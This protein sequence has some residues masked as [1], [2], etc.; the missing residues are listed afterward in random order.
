MK[1]RILSANDV[2]A[3][4]PIEQAIEAMRVAFREIASGGAH[5]PLRT[6]LR[7]GAG[8]TLFMPGYLETSGGLAQKIVSVYNENP[9]RGLPAISGLVIVLDP[10]TGS[11]LAVLEGGAL[12]AIRTGAAAG[13]ATDLL[14]RPNSHVLAQFGAGG[15]AYDHVAAVVAVRPIEEVRIVSRSGQSCKR[16]AQRL[17]AEGINAFSVQD[18]AEAVREADIITCVT[19]AGQALFRDE[20][21]KS[22]AHINLMG[23]YTPDM[24]EAPAETVARA[25]VF[26]D[27]LE[28]ALAEAGDLLKPLAEGRIERSHFQ[29][30][31][32]D[33]LLGRVPGRSS[34]E[35]I[36]LFKSV[37]LA[38][39]DVAAA[40]RA[41]TYAEAKGLGEIV[42]L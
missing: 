24:Q 4:L 32:G 34:N 12:T 18:A 26:I 19:P 2:R 42:A 41:L 10:R 23:A 7:T 33:L 31:L 11:P 13:L 8:V 30:T 21:V 38:A 22:G 15:M 36:T 1:L 37:G 5:I 40:A 29:R 14:A 28:A 25:H 17:R 6:S 35:E 16:L 9:S 39:Q 27:Q 20:D 3:A